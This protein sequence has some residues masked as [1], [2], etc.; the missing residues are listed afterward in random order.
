MSVR[1][2]LKCTVL[3]SRPCGDACIAN[4][5]V[6]EGLGASDVLK[7]EAV[8]T[9]IIRKYQNFDRPWTP[10]IVSDSAS[11]FL[12]YQTPMQVPNDSFV[13]YTS[14]GAPNMEPG[15]ESLMLMRV[16]QLNSASIASI[17]RCPLVWQADCVEGLCCLSLLCHAG[18]SSIR[19]PRECTHEAGQDRRSAR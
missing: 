15:D 8:W 3:C 10:D 14:S 19:E 16:P 13:E 5:Y 17:D 2:C 1:S 4:A 9:S 7:E 11:I 12:K 18:W 6:Q